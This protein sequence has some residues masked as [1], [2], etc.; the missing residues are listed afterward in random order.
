MYSDF[1]FMVNCIKHV[2][3]KVCKTKYTYIKGMLT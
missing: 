1:L 2:D 3:I